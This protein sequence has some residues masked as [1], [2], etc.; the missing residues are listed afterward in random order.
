MRALGRRRASNETEIRLTK[1]GLF[2]YINMLNAPHNLRAP[3]PTR[4]EPRP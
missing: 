1:A 4:A 3:A 2:I